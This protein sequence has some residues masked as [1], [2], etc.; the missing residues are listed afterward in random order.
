[1]SAWLRIAVAL[2]FAILAWQLWSRQPG[3]DVPSPDGSASGQ[4]GATAT[5][6]AAP[7]RYPAF[8][9]PEAI[10]TLEA[11]ERGGPFPYDR[12]GSVFQNR[13]R[14]LPEQPRGYYHEY[15]VETPGSP[16]RG[17]RRI[18]SGGEP[19]EVYFYT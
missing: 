18:V 6:P 1:M 3:M 13:E 9:P 4:P 14:R 19:P 7:A 5:V 2:L 12:D 10:S 8:L 15:T 17:A 16:D 11:I